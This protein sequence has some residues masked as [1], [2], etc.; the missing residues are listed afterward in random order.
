MGPSIFI[1]AICGL[2][3]SYSKE[4]FT[5]EITINPNMTRK[6]ASKNPFLLDLFFAC[7]KTSA[8]IDIS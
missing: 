4:L 1:L 3:F 7:S 8:S 6:N 5:I 2:F